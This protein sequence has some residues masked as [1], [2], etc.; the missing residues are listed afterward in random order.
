MPNNMNINNIE[1]TSTWIDDCWSA[2]E[3]S[4]SHGLCKK[5]GGSANNKE[6]RK[7]LMETSLKSLIV[8]LGMGHIKFFITFR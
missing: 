2:P 5:G 4:V 3:D 1:G 8:L 6:K 7:V